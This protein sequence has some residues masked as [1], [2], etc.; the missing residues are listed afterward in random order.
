MGLASPA[1]SSTWYAVYYS[2]TT[3]GT[4]PT[5]SY[6]SPSYAS[7]WKDKKLSYEPPKNW[8]W[9]NS[10]REENRWRCWVK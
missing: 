3:S 5:R 7:I 4:F 1:V 9:Y 6:P 10:F 8:R 2:G